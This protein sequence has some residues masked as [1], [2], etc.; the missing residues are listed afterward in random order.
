MFINVKIRACLITSFYG[1]DGAILLVG[2][3][4]SNRSWTVAPCDMQTEP[5]ISSFSGTPG[6]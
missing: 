3:S 6:E 2:G 4:L 5:Y 1:Q